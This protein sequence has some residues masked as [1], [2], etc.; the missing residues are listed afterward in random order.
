MSLLLGIGLFLKVAPLN[1]SFIACQCIRA[2]TRIDPKGLSNT[3]FR[4]DLFVNFCRNPEKVA[5]TPLS[6]FL[7]SIQIP[8]NLSVILKRNLY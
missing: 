1:F 2:N 3:A 5:N 7:K 6:L 8:T 4:I